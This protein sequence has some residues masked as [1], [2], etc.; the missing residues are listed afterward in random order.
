LKVSS[1]IFISSICSEIFVLVAIK[2]LLPVAIFAFCA[3]GANAQVIFDGAC[4]NVT[5]QQDFQ[6]GDV[7]I[8]F[9]AQVYMLI[10]LLNFSILVDGMSTRSTLPSSSKMV[11]AHLPLMETMEMELSQSEII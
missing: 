10:L 9:D 11:C 7:K 5:V 4:P 8:Y 1:F 6:L 3:L 2:G